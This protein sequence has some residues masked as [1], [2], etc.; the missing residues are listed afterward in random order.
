MKSFPVLRFQGRT[1]SPAILKGIEMNALI[2]SET[3]VEAFRRGFDNVTRIK[4]Q[5]PA[6]RVPTKPRE[7]KTPLALRVMASLSGTASSDRKRDRSNNPPIAGQYAGPARAKAIDLGRN[8]PC[9]CGSGKKF[10]K[11]CLR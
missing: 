5:L 10:K 8:E 3:A 4:S 11:C 9:H 7:I 6:Q 2:P 1:I